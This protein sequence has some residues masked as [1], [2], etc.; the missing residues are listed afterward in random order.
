[1][2]LM[3]VFP[4]DAYAQR[5]GDIFADR[6]FTSYNRPSVPSDAH[7]GADMFPPVQ[8]FVEP[9]AEMFSRARPRYDFG[10]EDMVKAHPMPIPYTPLFLPPP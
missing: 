2:G 3:A 10:R 4:V 7:R 1:M 6:G 5:T 9:T 8:G